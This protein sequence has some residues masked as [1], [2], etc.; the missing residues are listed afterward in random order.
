M[1]N[2]IPF[3]VLSCAIHLEILAADASRT[4]IE[5]VQVSDSE[6]EDSS[7]D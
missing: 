6:S 5:A 7:V 2:D 3:Q 4:K 1:R